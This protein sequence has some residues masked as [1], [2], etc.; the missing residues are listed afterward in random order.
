MRLRR[1]RWLTV[2]LHAHL[3]GRAGGP[4]VLWAWPVC[5]Y[6]SGVGRHSETARQ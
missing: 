5:W 3:H 6:R 1:Y 4:K 2:R